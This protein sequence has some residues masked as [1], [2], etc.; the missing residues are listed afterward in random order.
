MS[1]ATGPGSGPASSVAPSQRLKISNLTRP[2]NGAGIET[3][4]IH[5]DFR[6]LRRHCADAGP[7]SPFFG[8]RRF[9]PF[10][11]PCSANETMSVFSQRDDGDKDDARLDNHQAESTTPQS[12]LAK[13]CATLPTKATT[14]YLDRDVVKRRE[15]LKRISKGRRMRIKSC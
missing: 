7:R 15:R 11:C 9:R 6:T 2:G 13:T 4:S 8:E 12:K 10:L 3:A 1:S 14:G 5:H